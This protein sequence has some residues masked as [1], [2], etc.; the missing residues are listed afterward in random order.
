MRG[1]ET[2]VG[3]AGAFD[4][5]SSTLNVVRVSACLAKG[6]CPHA[7]SKTAVS[8]TA[9][10]G[11]ICFPWAKIVHTVLIRQ[12]LIVKRPELGRLSPYLKS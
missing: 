9:F 12:G 10:L 2:A 7:A 6:A 5:G 8:R 3:L 11:I 1:P 4:A